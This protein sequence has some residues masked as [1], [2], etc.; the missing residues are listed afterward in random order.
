MIV[1]RLQ[2]LRISAVS[3]SAIL[4]RNPRRRIFLRYRLYQPKGIRRRL[5]G[6]RHSSGG[7]SNAWRHGEEAGALP[8]ARLGDNA[9]AVLESV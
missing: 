8:P 6:S 4:L 1:Y 3:P 7:P 5:G 9:A 2:L